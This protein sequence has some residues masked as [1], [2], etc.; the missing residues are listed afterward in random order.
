MQLKMKWLHRNLAFSY[1]NSYHPQFLEGHLR[2]L[3]SQILVV[4]GLLLVTA[5]S[6]MPVHQ[7]VPNAVH[8]KL[9]T[10]DVILPI[11]QSE[12]YVF[13]PPRRAVRDLACSGL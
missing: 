3:Y 8:D 7:P 9:G 4:L 11:Q 13:V 1:S 6:S 12:I 5:C 2:T 10:T